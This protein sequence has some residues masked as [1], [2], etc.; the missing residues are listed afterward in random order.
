[1]RPQAGISLLEILI[2]VAM[3]G[4]VAVVSIPNL[5]STDPAILDLAAEEIAQAYRFAR[6]ESLRTG[7]PYGVYSV[8][9]SSN[10]RY[11]V[12]RANTTT[13]PPTPIYDVYHPLDKQLYDLE[14]EK[15]AFA[16][17][18]SVTAINNFYGTCDNPRYIVFN[19]QG[20]PLCGD[21]LTVSL[22]E[23]AITLTKGE[24]TRVVTIEGLTGRVSLQ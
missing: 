10:K 12:Y 2:V 14:L 8:S 1:L 11:R 21:P 18:E 7:E 17:A 4:I 15:H 5:S 22:K 13:T 9:S 24:H 6:A 23:K 20:V 19:A 3:L 16:S